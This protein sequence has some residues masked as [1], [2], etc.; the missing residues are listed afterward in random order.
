MECG[1]FPGFFFFFFQRLNEKNIFS[2][3]LLEDYVIGNM[4]LSF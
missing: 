1:F 4:T 2:N 3:L